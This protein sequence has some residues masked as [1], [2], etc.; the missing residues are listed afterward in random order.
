M[1]KHSEDSTK[2]SAL[3]WLP[4]S[5][6]DELGQRT[7]VRLIIR[8]RENV[9]SCGKMSRWSLFYISK[10][11]ELQG[12]VKPISIKV[13]KTAPNVS[14]WNNIQRWVRSRLPRPAQITN[15]FV[16]D[17]L[18]KCDT[19]WCLPIMSV[20]NKALFP[21]WY[22]SL[23]SLWRIEVCLIYKY[24]CPTSVRFGRS[25]N[26]KQAQFPRWILYSLGIP[27]GIKATAPILIQMELLMI[28]CTLQLPK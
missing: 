10:Y 15:V 22:S 4:P 14:S 5:E 8:L 12:V 2:Q 19:L 16:T 17:R 25:E 11:S 26:R 21:I 7:V 18:L 3:Y 27:S 6:I 23:E 1:V 28:Y 9:S 13:Y 20:C 24:F